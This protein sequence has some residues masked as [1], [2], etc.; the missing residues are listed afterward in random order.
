[1]L[2]FART[3]LPANRLQQST[4]S[5]FRPMQEMRQQT[6]E[7]EEDQARWKEQE[8]ILKLDDIVEDL[9]DDDD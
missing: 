3:I 6:N 1:V 9:E 8:E 5:Y 4:H 7:E 2:P